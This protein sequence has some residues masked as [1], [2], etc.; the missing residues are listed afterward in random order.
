M[1]PSTKRNIADKAIGSSIHLAHNSVALPPS[2]QQ[3]Y[4]VQMRSPEEMFDRVLKEF[5]KRVG[6]EKLRELQA[7]DISGLKKELKKIQDEQ[8]K[9]RSLR[10]PRRI[11]R[12]VEAIQ[13]LG[14]VI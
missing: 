2:D 13:Q 12:F 14:Q 1:C 4:V 6:E 8:K 3:A 11:Q 9:S 7:T 10:N 5:K